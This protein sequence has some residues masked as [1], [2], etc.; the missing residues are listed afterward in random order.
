RVAYERPE[1]QVCRP[2]ADQHEGASRKAPRHHA[3]M[4]GVTTTELIRRLEQLL[5][6]GTVAEVDLGAARCRVK[7]GELL[8]NWVPWFAQRAGQTRHW[9]PP[10]VGEQCLLLSPGGDTAAAVA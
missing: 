3:G 9:S 6:Y 2:P 4:H 7:S 5:R 1:L 10:T 8:S